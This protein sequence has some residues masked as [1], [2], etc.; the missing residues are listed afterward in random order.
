[1]FGIGGGQVGQL[2]VRLTADARQY[3]TT[4]ATAATYTKSITKQMTGHFSSMYGM[5]GGMAVTGM[6]GASVKAYANFDQAMTESTSIMVGL[7][8]Q[9]KQAMSDLAKTMSKET[10]TSSTELAKAYYYL[11]S[12]GYDV[13]QSMANLPVVEK[14]AV[15]GMFD[16]S[17]ATTLL[18]DSQAALGLKSKDAIENQKQMKRVS[19]VLVRANTLAN[20]SVEQ[21]AESLTTKAAASARLL[22]KSVEETVAVLAAYADQGMKSANSGESFAIITRDLQRAIIKQNEAWKANGLSVYDNQGKMLSYAD[23]IEQLEDKFASLT[24]M[25]KRQLSMSL[26]FQDRSF[27]ALQSLMGTSD[28]IREYEE[29]LKKAAGFTEDVA[30]KQMASFNSQMT[31]M[32][33]KI[34]VAG[35]A[36]GE[37]LAPA[38]LEIGGLV[39]DIT[40]KFKSWGVVMDDVAAKAA[41][42]NWGKYRTGAAGLWELVKGIGGEL[43]SWTPV[44][45]GMAWLDDMDKQMEEARAI[46]A[47]STVF[48]PTK[49]AETLAFGNVIKDAI[50]GAISLTSQEAE[51][52]KKLADYTKQVTD[53][54]VELFT[55]IGTNGEVA[56]QKY[57][58]GLQTATDALDQHIISKEKFWELEKKL[59]DEYEKTI[60]NTF[61][62]AADDY[63]K[64]RESMDLSPMMKEIQANKNVLYNA[65]MNG[66]IG[67]EEYS[68]RVNA[69]WT[70]ST[71]Q[72][73]DIAG[74]QSLGNQKQGAI[75]YSSQQ[76]KMGANDYS[77]MMNQ[78][79]QNQMSANDYSRMMSQSGMMGV[80]QAEMA[81][82]YNAQMYGGQTS[83]QK[84]GEAGVA[85]EGGVM[86]LAQRAGLAHAQTPER[87]ME[88]QQKIMVELLT[89]IRDNTLNTAN[90]W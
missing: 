20:A 19:D 12:A 81:Q 44:G 52:Q 90:A 71:G 31:I 25:Q 26:G 56:L 17:K 89:D 53:E 84:L 73:P 79:N 32:W 45:M 14:F 70:K 82:W 37:Q 50:N 42:G 36:L 7:T 21:F 62:K 5:M 16:L 66:I 87:R 59:R 74:W 4:L 27:N 8:G 28:K 2:Y 88:E 38:I 49:N 75:T 48:D 18:A 64:L 68:N 43:L 15:A 22:G 61:Q 77:R 39:V 29:E 6:I 69:L 1:M 80:S 11:A 76:G 67:A 41:R 72:T 78:Q 85:D 58:T 35:S 86:G 57:Q 24:D 55:E 33:N 3:Q 46:L 34:K 63:D 13:Q 10:I 30:N 65:W 40:G 47:K 9:Q 60:P 83:P 54:F 51:E 23:I